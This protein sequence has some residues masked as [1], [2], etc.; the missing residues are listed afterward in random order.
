[1]QL[2]DLA[3][4][5]EVSPHRGHAP[6]PP[7]D[8][9]RFTRQL[10]MS[11]LFHCPLLSARRPNEAPAVLAGRPVHRPNWT[12]G[13]GRNVQPE[14]ERFIILERRSSSAAGI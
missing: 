9:F 5:A 1:M 4:L 7:D 8:F 2:C 3:V 11:S 10:L 6:E 13:T 14:I 12:T